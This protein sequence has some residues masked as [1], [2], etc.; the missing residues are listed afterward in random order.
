MQREKRE[1]ESR[2]CRKRRESKR[3]EYAEREYRVDREYKV[4]RMRV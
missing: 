4:C 3:V 2:V 1:W